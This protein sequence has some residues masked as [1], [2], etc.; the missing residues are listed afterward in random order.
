MSER[1][2]LRRELYHQ[3]KRSGFCVKCGKHP[4]GGLRSLCSV[5][6]S[7]EAEQMRERRAERM[8]RGVCPECGH[9]AV[10]NGLCEKHFLKRQRLIESIQAK[11]ERCLVSDKCRQ[12]GREA[13]TKKRRKYRV[14]EICYLKSMAKCNLGDTQRWHELKELFE[15]QSICPYTG[16]VLIMGL[17]TTLDHKVAVS[18]GGGNEIDNL[19][20]VYLEEYAGFD[21]NR[22]KGA[23]NDDEYK[24]AIAIQY[25]HIFG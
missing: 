14:C 1:N 2:A 3:R 10:E 22:M 25:K 16:I 4:I 24:N 17:N 20:W 8:A 19:Q 11:R 9:E 13:I 6:A 18:K 23:L 21:V 7:K 5:C 15:K 12:C